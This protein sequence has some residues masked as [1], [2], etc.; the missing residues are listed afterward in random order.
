MAFFCLDGDKSKVTLDELKAARKQA[1]ASLRPCAADAFMLF[2]VCS[3]F[4]W[5]L[6]ASPY[7]L[8]QLFVSPQDLCRLVNAEQ[9]TWLTGL[10]EMTRTFG[11]ELME[12]VL[13]D[14]PHIFIR[15]RVHFN[16]QQNTALQ[17][18]GACR[19][20]VYSTPSSASSSRSSCVL[21]SSNSSHPVSSTN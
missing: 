21:S 15:V 2:Q 14:F 1:P 20:H 4:L 6:N 9:P 17:H 7:L 18:T 16:H 12:S 8:F 19:G 3:A 11:L 10:T 13:T 5:I